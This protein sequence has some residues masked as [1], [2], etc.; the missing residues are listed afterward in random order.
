VFA[1]GVILVFGVIAYFMEENGFP[2]APAILGVIL[3]TMLEEHFITSMIKY[4]GPVPRL[5]RAADRGGAGDRDDPRLAVAAR[6]AAAVAPRRG[7]GL[8]SGA[9]PRGR[10]SRP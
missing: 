3:G 4:R 1:V 5:L 8:E 2:V 6:E 7:P 10:P 9:R